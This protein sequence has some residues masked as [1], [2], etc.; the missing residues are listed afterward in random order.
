MDFSNLDSTHR[1]FCVWVGLVLDLDCLN[2]INN[3]LK[4]NEYIL[5]NDIVSTACNIVMI[6][7][8]LF[9]C[10]SSETRVILRPS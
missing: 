6:I 4:L 7:D 2:R 3:Q 5:A 10:Q 8:H 9:I 1:D